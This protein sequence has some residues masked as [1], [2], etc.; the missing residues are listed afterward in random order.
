MNALWLRQVRGI[1][2]LEMRKTLFSAR[3]L[4]L[5]MMAL[6][7]VGLVTLFVIMHKLLGD[8]GD[9]PS[10]NSFSLFYAVLYQFILRL[11]LFIGCGIHDCA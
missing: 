4:P 6:L 11:L 8:D 5:Y 3:A 2:G 9:I 10:L 7:P 1:L